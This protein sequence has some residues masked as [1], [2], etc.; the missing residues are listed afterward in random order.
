M[1]KPYLGEADHQADRKK[2][3]KKEKPAW[4]LK[5]RKTKKI[6]YWYI[7]YH[8][9][10]VFVILGSALTPM[11]HSFWTAVVCSLNTCNATASADLSVYGIK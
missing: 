10:L 9:G 11:M 5:H 3:A 8:N 6:S 7:D 2:K 4:A 1:D